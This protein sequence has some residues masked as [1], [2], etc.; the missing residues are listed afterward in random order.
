MLQEFQLLTAKPVLFVANVS[1]GAGGE[2]PQVQSVRELAE[3]KG[4]RMTTI[5][6]Q[7]EAELSTLRA[8]ERQIYLRELGLKESGL[9]RLTA[10]AYDLLKLITFFTA[11]EEESRAWPVREGTKAA[12]AA[13]KIH[14][15]MERGFIRAEVYAYS[16]LM[17]C[18]TPA[19]VRE[20]GLFRL[21]GREYVIRDGDVVYFRFNV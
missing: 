17:T 8:D 6:G 12:A 14:S 9:A 5:C 3:K 20:N 16:D 13:G 19:A 4:A 18:G 15:D 2:D 7:L 11:G 1:E 10:A 21:E